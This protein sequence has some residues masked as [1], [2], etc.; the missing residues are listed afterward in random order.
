MAT[1]TCRFNTIFFNKYFI[2][3]ENKFLKNTPFAAYTTVEN[4]S[5]SSLRLLRY[6]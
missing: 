2:F 1:K 4:C 5:N 6:K 3:S